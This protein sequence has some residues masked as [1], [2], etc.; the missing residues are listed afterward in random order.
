MKFLQW[1]QQI[2]RWEIFAWVHFHSILVSSLWLKVFLS[3]NV[4]ETMLYRKYKYDRCELSKVQRNLPILDRKLAQ[5]ER[6][7]MA[8]RNQSPQRTLSTQNWFTI[9]EI[10]EIERYLQKRNTV[11]K[12]RIIEFWMQHAICWNRFGYLAYSYK[13]HFLL[14][15]ILIL[16]MV[17][18]EAQTR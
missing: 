4:F 16:M 18:G 10:G 3:V 13:L 2:S 8:E 6:F 14:M 17:F 5:C 11:Y 7:W 15:D 1:L 12:P 9:I